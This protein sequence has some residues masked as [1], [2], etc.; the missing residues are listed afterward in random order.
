MDSITTGH[1]GIVLASMSDRSW[2]GMSASVA[3]RRN[4]AAAG[5]ASLRPV[6]R[7][8]PEV[9]CYDVR[10]SGLDAADR[11]VVAATDEISALVARGMTVA[12]HQ[13]STL[14]GPSSASPPV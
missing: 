5:S 11:A 10:T 1:A 14:L 2:L 7:P 12:D 9:G 8:L 3:A 6:V 13:F 4:P